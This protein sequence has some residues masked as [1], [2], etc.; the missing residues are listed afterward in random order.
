MNGILT[1]FLAGS[2]TSLGTRSY[3]ATESKAIENKSTN[4]QQV[5]ASDNK[6]YFYSYP[7]SS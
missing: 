7:C 1:T 6:V 4:F 3:R 2:V 5:I